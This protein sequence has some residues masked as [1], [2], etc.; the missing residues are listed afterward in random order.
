MRNNVDYS[1]YEGIKGTLKNTLSGSI[2]IK[3]DGVRVRVAFVCGGPITTNVRD[4]CTL[5][6][7]QRPTYIYNIGQAR[8]ETL[9]SS[10]GDKLGET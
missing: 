9:V 4:H 3:Y 7:T 5:W 1:R 2:R 10:I 6:V 8:V